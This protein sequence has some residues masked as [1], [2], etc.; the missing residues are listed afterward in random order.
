MGR[1]P[2]GYCLKRHCRMVLGRSGLGR[3]A[4]VRKGYGRRRGAG[5]RDRWAVTV[6]PGAVVS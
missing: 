5:S 4:L 1:G 2:Q 6:R 3:T